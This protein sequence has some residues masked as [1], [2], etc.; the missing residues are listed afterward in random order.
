VFGCGS[1]KEREER[2]RGSEGGGYRSNYKEY[3]YDGAAYSRKGRA[4]VQS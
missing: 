2:E 4:I 1:Q 3:K